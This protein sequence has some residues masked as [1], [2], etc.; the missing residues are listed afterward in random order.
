MRN[1]HATRVAGAAAAGACAKTGMGT[2]LLR[3]RD[4]EPV[5]LD[6]IAF[7][8]TI[9]DAAVAAA[10][11]ATTAAAPDTRTKRDEERACR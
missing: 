4:T 2:T 9:A 5:L 1:P 11:T 3:R 8:T 6:S 7:T 10:A